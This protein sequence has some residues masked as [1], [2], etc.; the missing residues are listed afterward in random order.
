MLPEEILPCGIVNLEGNFVRTKRY[1]V[2][3][4]NEGVEGNGGACFKCDRRSWV[5]GV[6]C[7]AVV[8]VVDFVEHDTREGRIGYHRVF[9]F[10]CFTAFSCGIVR[11]AKRAEAR[12]GA[13]SSGASCASTRTGACPR[14]CT[15][16]NFREVVFNTPA[17]GAR[18]EVDIPPRE[19]SVLLGAANYLSFCARILFADKRCVRTAI[20]TD[21]QWA[22]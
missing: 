16:R 21:I 6:V 11:C 4:T 13:G 20:G 14:T 2:W 22:F 15:T 5:L 17:I 7:P 10:E 1:A 12:S 8:F 9:Y 19:A 18:V 3:N